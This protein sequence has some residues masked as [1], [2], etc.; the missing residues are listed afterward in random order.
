MQEVIEN[1]LGFL[2]LKIL[3]ATVMVATVYFP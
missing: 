1:A 3:I 2:P